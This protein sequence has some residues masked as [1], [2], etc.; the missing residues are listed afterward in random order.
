MTCHPQL[1][2][3]VMCHYFILFDKVLEVNGGGSVINGAQPCMAEWLLVCVRDYSSQL[4]SVL[5]K[6]KYKSKAA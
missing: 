1:V 2:T 3:Q 4:V 6:G 5:L